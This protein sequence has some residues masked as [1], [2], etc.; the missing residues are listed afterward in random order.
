MPTR[1]RQIPAQGFERWVVVTGPGLAGAFEVYWA[2]GQPLNAAVLCVGTARCR[3]ADSIRQLLTREEES[4]F[5]RQRSH[6]G[7]VSWQGRVLGVLL[8]LLVSSSWL[9]ARAEAPSPAGS[10]ASVSPAPPPRDE[11]IEAMKSRLE[12]LEGLQDSMTA[13]SKGALEQ[14]TLSLQIGGAFFGIFLV[15]SSYKQFVADRGQ[16]DQDKEM[17][18]LM[19]SFQGN[20]TAITSL[21]TTLKDAYAY[22]TEMRTDLER[23]DKGLDEMK[24]STGKADQLRQLET[25]KLRREAVE[26]FDSDVNR[27]NLG[28]EETSRQLSQFAERVRTLGTSRDV[29]SD[30]NPFAQYL[31]GLHYVSSYQYPIALEWFASAERTASTQLA[32]LSKHLYAPEHLEKAPQ[33]LREMLTLCA[34]FQGVC[35]KNT[36]D[37]Q[38]SLSKFRDAV[39]RDPKHL[40]SKTYLLQVMYLER[41]IPV[42]EIEKHYTDA[43]AEYQRWEREAELPGDK[44]RKYFSVLKTY[45]GNMYL[46]KLLPRDGQAQ[47][48]RYEHPEKAAACYAEA[49]DANEHETTAFALA[50]GLEAVGVALH[51]GQNPKQ[52]YERALRGLKKKITEDHDHLFA[53]TLYYM[54]AICAR[55]VS[56]TREASELFLAQARHCLKLVPAN[57]SCFSPLSKIRLERREILDEM[58]DFERLQ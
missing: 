38:R 50:Q 17:R 7:H 43:L 52:L 25:E 44:L 45:Q 55:K 49:F 13:V 20:I 26:N 4:L 18:G 36:G 14:M 42:S 41:S 35:Y 58:E 24:A 1:L 10:G 33:Q 16:A 40:Q 3:H 23:L 28:R 54:L 31:C 19:A 57:V 21:V 6:G 53:V 22:R 39:A 27:K 2:V 51:G 8:A 11:A 12:A 47:R 5:M 46:R 48:Q 34:Y 15:F 32:G 56:A 9:V 29:E 30:L 37:Y